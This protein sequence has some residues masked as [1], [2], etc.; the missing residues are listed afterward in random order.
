MT[1]RLPILAILVGFWAC[2]HADARTWTSDNGKYTV[3]A[4]LVGVEDGKVLLRKQNGDVIR[5]PL[6][7]LS[8]ADQAYVK[9]ATDEAAART[10]PTGGATPSNSPTSEAA[11]STCQLSL[12]R[13][14]PRSHPDY[15]RSSTL[16]SCLYRFLSPQRFSLYYASSK[17]DE[18]KSREMAE[19]AAAFER[20][21]RKQ[22]D[23]RSAHPFRGVARFGSHEYAFILDSRPQAI[24]EE[25]SKP[26]SQRLA[27]PEYS[28]FFFDANHNG[29]LTDDPVIDA[30]PPGP[31]SSGGEFPPVEV[32]V[33]ADGTDTPYVFHI[34]VG[35]GQWS[36]GPAVWVYFGPA[37]YR[38]GTITLDGT[39]MHVFLLDYN[40]N[41]RF[42][43]ACALPTTVGPSDQ[44]IYPVVG[45]TLVIE[46]D[47]NRAE[48]QPGGEMPRSSQHYVSKLLQLEYRFYQM[49]ISPAGDRLTL[50]PFSPPMG[51]ISSADLDFEAVLFGDLG[52]VSIA[53]G[54]SKPA[55]VPAGNWQLMAY[56]IRRAGP[57]P[58][59]PVSKVQ[60]SSKTPATRSKGS[61][62]TKV[63][64]GSQS[65]SNLQRSELSA[66]GTNQCR[67]IQV[68][69]GET[70]AFP[71]GSSYHPV[72]KGT[73]LRAG[74]KADLN[75]LLV[76]SGGEVCAG[77]LRVHGKTPP[78]PRLTIRDRQ[79]KIV[80]SGKLE[81]G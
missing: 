28:R 81:F 34:S 68:R 38:E 1:A 22:P 71:F 80:E 59:G 48:V 24:L 76:G 39:P 65:D 6:K 2:S 46:P 72:V 62:S 40:T 69:Q 58:A 75:V 66:R 3:E 16:F 9:K 78:P 14:K 45:D 43:D 77:I 17:Q 15:A 8:A 64:A 50:T 44:V 21:V 70:V 10:Q 11:S 12:Q 51:S 36:G 32:T 37:A 67:P 63:P 4:H 57:D 54:P 49:T 74:Q 19:Q 79:G 7:R 20:I 33:D 47:A 35:T 18:V 41:G 53:G 61:R 56:S 29:D 30:E 23:L 42:D 5:V 73:N 60:E 25:S 31:G 27:A 26:A 52:M 55:P 13:W